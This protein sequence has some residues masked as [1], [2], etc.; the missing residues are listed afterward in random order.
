METDK[1]VKNCE[2]YESIRDKLIIIRNLLQYC[3]ETNRKES[4]IHS[5]NEHL[6]NTQSIYILN[7]FLQTI[8][9]ELFAY[10]TK[11]EVFEVR[12]CEI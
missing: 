8:E 11:Q 4:T 1:F 2:E 12:T 6:Q 3:D 9:D 5:L 10:I 7:D